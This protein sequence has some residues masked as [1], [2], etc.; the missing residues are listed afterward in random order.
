MAITSTS[1]DIACRTKARYADEEDRH[2]NNADGIHSFPDDSSNKSTLGIG[3]VM[4]GKLTRQVI[5]ELMQACDKIHEEYE[6]C[7]GCPIFFNCLLENTVE[8][9]WDE[10][11]AGRIQDFLDYADDLDE[12]QTYDEWIDEL[13][14][15]YYRDR[16]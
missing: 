8:Q 5:D 12:G 9:L 13:N 7:D 10:V 1:R 15:G 3:E 4:S 14:K 2:G 6:A 16:L 11:S